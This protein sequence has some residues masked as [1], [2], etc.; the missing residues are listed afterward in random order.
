MDDKNIEAVEQNPYT[1]ERESLIKTFISKENQALKRVGKRM[2][3]KEIDIIRDYSRM[4]HRHAR[5][6]K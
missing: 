6:T 1:K 3:E 5:S 4:Y 2:S